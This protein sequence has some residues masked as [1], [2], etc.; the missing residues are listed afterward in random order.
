MFVSGNLATKHKDT[1]TLPKDPPKGRGAIGP[2]EEVWVFEA[3]P[4]LRLVEVSGATPVDPQQTSLLTS[5]RRFS[6]YRV[7]PGQSLVLRERRRGDAGT[8]LDQLKLHRTIW[9]DFDG[10]GL[11]IADRLKGK[12]RQSTRLEALTTTKLG[13]VAVGGRDQF[14][15]RHGKFIGVE[16]PRGPISLTAESRYEADPSHIPAIGWR[17]DVQSL[18]ATLN[19]PPGWRLFRATGVDNAPNTWIGRWTL[20]DMFLVLI[21][22]LAIAR[23]FGWKIGVLA[24]A[25][26]RMARL[27]ESSDTC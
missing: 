1:L 16:V 18:S 14:I 3:R 6:S 11:T 9:L 27:F 12:L 24:L 15:T 17:H 22:G 5:W 7:A 4:S 8:S 10:G 20:L 19:L 2:R 26:I 25:C 23:L 21:L 13:R